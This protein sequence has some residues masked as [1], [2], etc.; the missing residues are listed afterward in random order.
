V[1]AP[2]G[3]PGIGWSDHWSFWQQGYPAVMITDTAPYR[4]PHYHQV[5][6]TPDKLNYDSYA[7]VVMGLAHTFSA[8]A[9]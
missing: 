6:D 4:Y 3:V 7:R 5:S 1:A 8:L 2:A 9:S